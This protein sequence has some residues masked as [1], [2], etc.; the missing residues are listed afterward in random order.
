METFSEKPPLSR[1]G[2]PQANSTTSSPRATSPAASEPT[3]PCSALIRAASSAARDRTSSRNANSTAARL[4]KDVSR[5]AG[6]AAAAAATAAPASAADAKST[7]PLTCPVA[8][9]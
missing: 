1:C 5:Q 9:L 4:V 7:V 6:K 3:F 8:G 2:R